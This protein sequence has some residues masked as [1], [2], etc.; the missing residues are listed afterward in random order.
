MITTNTAYVVKSPIYGYS[1]MGYTHINLLH[2]AFDTE[3]EA[4]KRKTDC[5]KAFKMGKSDT[6]LCPESDAEQD[7]FYREM[8]D[9]ISYRFTGESK[10][11]IRSITVDE[12][13]IV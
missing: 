9:H 10:I 13:E 11:Y 5:D 3:E 8:T 2:E 7:D 12:K 4:R 1:G 6:F